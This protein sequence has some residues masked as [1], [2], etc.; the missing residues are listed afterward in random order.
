MAAKMKSD[1]PAKLISV[2]HPPAREATAIGLDAKAIHLL[3]SVAGF[4]A[5]V[6]PT[7]FGQG[8]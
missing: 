3:S 4:P 1:G 7:T 8:S 2:R 6:D 5:A